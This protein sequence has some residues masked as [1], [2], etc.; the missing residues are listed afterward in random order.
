MLDNTLMCKIVVHPNLGI[1]EG[2]LGY[3][4]YF[5]IQIVKQASTY[6]SS[7]MGC[8]KSWREVCNNTQNI[9]PLIPFT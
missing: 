3:M 7:K 9:K 6:F 5:C 2:G 4:C 8:K 1:F